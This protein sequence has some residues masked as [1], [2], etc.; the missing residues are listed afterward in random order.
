MRFSKPVAGY[1]MLMIL[2]DVD[3]QTSDKE[4]KVIRK[5][6]S[7]N[8]SEDIDFDL[9]TEKIRNINPVDYPL[10][11]NDAMNSFYLESS[12]EDRNHFLDFAVKLVIADKNISPKENLFLHEL[13]MA[14]EADTD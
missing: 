11:F 3:G 9:E 10:H 8:F 13:F 2:A 7:E 14:W 6:M 5:Y 4:M 12:R 1:H